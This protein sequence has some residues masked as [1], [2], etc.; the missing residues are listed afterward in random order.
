MY[1]DY[2]IFLE[3]PAACFLVKPLVTISNL[4]DHITNLI[5]MEGNAGIIFLPFLPGT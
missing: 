5:V 2:G 4:V 1:D 3:A